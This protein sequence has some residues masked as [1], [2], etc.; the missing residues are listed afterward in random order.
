MVASVSSQTCL[1]SLAMKIRLFV[2]VCDFAWSCDSNEEDCIPQQL[3]NVK[4][5]PNCRNG[6]RFL[7]RVHNN[8]LLSFTTQL[9]HR[10]IAL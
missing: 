4:G 10:T 1:F 3:K 8:S 7:Y 2:V 6:I 9:H 5:S